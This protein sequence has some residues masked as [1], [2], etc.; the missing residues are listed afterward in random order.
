MEEPHEWL[1]HEE[2][3]IRYVLKECAKQFNENQALDFFPRKLELFLEDIY[4][5]I[6]EWDESTQFGP[7]NNEKFIAIRMITEGF[8]HA[9]K[10]HSSFPH[11]LDS[12]TPMGNE[13]W[14]NKIFWLCRMDNRGIMFCP[15]ER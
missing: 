12:T 7:S 9:K 6:K 1:D 10:V 14:V 3:S 4:S 2:H 13:Q 5:P 15:H 11:V 8:I